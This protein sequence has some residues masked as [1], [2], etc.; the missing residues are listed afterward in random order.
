MDNYINSKNIK[1]I[2]D[3][4]RRFSSMLYNTVK[5]V[6]QKASEDGKKWE[7]DPTIINYNLCCS[8]TRSCA[9][10]SITNVFVDDDDEVRVTL[11]TNRT[12]EICNLTYRDICGLLKTQNNLIKKEDVEKLE[13]MGN[14]LSKILLSFLREI[15]NEASPFSLIIGVDSLNLQDPLCNNLYEVSFKEINTIFIND[16]DDKIMV[17]LCNNEELSADSLTCYDLLQIIQEVA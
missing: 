9:Q 13:S 16:N 14:K 17:G 5:K 2:E 10:T 8:D 12:V 11:D 7:I 6:T 3:F 4:E 1:K 15:I